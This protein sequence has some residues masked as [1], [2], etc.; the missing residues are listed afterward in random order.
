MFLKTLQASG[1][2]EIILTWPVAAKGKIQVTK[3][4]I[5]VPEQNSPPKSSTFCRK[6][7]IHD[8]AAVLDSH[9]IPVG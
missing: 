2:N 3:K 5:S 4:C 8:Q 1:R 6:K 9:M 7:W